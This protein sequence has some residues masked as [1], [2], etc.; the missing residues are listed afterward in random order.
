M[1]NKIFPHSVVGVNTKYLFIFIYLYIFISFYIYKH[2]KNKI[3]NLNISLLH[4]VR[5]FRQI[6]KYT[7][8][9]H[10]HDLVYLLIS[11]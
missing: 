10:F 1:I 3:V 11:K 2:L 6:S 7:F 8:I 9:L 4:N 5:L